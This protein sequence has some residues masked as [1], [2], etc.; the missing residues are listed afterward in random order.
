MPFSPYC[1]LTEGN[2][3]CLEN[4]LLSLLSWMRRGTSG[5]RRCCKLGFTAQLPSPRGLSCD[6]ADY[7]GLQSQRVLAWNP[8][9]ENPDSKDW[10]LVTLLMVHESY[11]PAVVGCDSDCHWGSLC[12]C[13]PVLKSLLTATIKVII[14]YL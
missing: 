13:W 7:H 12:H 2:V 8:V 1:T 4:Y 5:R 11:K 6:E 14:H 3:H 10:F 9:Q